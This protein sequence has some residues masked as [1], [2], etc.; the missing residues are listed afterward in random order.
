MIPGNY[1]MLVKKGIYYGRK[2]ASRTVMSIWGQA[3]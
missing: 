1:V 2:G 3:E